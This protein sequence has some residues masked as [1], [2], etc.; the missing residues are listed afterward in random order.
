MCHSAGSEALGTPC[1]NRKYA[2]RPLIHGQIRLFKIVYAGDEVCCHIQPFDLAVCPAFEA[3]S[4][5]WS[6]ASFT[7]HI[8]IGQSTHHVTE[9]LFEALKSM[10]LTLSTQ[11]LW[12]DQ[13]CINQDDN[14]EKATQ[15]GLMS[16]IY[17]KAQR[18]IVWLGVDSHESALAMEHVEG[19]AEL[20]KSY[21]FDEDFARSS[22][23]ELGFPHEDEQVWPAFQYL[24]KRNYFKRLWVIQ[25]M[26]FSRNIVF[27]CGRLSASWD[28]FNTLMFA[29]QRYSKVAYD[30]LYKLNILAGMSKVFYCLR[31]Q[32]EMM[33]L[34][35]KYKGQPAGGPEVIGLLEFSRN[36]ECTEPL[37]R[38]Y[39]V[40][41]L[42]ADDDIRSQITISYAENDK[43][44]YW[45][46]YAQLFNALI[47]KFLDGGYFFTT[48]MIG[49]RG[50]KEMPS[51][52]PD[53]T[54]HGDP[55]RPYI[56]RGI[57]GA[58]KI[59]ENAKWKPR[60]TMITTTTDP[61]CLRIIGKSI[62][63]INQLIPFFPL[64]VPV[65][66]DQLT[67]RQVSALKGPV[68]Q[69]LHMAEST[70]SHS[71]D[72]DF[73]QVMMRCLV[74]NMQGFSADR[75][76][77]ESLTSDFMEFLDRLNA[78]I[79]HAHHD[80]ELDSQHVSPGAAR[81][82][83]AFLQYTHGRAMFKTESG[84]LGLCSADAQVGDEVAIFFNFIYPIVLRPV[85]DREPQVN[86]V[87]PR[88]VRELLGLCYVD[89]IMNGE[90]FD[91]RDLA[92]KA[93]QNSLSYRPTESLAVVVEKERSTRLT[94]SRQSEL[95]H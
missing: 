89:G 10:H 24:L 3:V 41:N 35:E 63:T 75:Y 20:I 44:Q 32:S 46:T 27:L 48:M 29:H 95:S 6:A 77:P 7:K 38:V 54:Q 94:R 88:V 58:G 25:E 9:H 84:M 30:S 68:M 33:G 93:S 43:E 28:D 1:I 78:V 50:R 56:P 49:H 82:A 2:H 23:V 53:L 66:F 64:P 4:Y 17:S 86:T 12:V 59:P 79:G 40:M 65:V 70:R 74:L 34:I 26:V 11:W 91:K 15:V 21:E 60:R 62:N 73:L 55:T 13:I 51:W 37:D 90:I 31:G 61:G 19:V 81:Y 83:A 85:S 67:C 57:M 92:R 18:A 16:Q 87:G 5:C 80:A 71:D 42:L 14:D 72:W 69:C 22:P 76:P 39:A 47:T 45:K 36:Q 52:C 8:N